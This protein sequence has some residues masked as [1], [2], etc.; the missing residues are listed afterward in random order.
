MIT[1]IKRFLLVSSSSLLLLFSAAVPVTVSA[2]GGGECGTNIG[3]NIADGAGATTGSGQP[4]DCDKEASDEG[5]GKI[6]KNIVNIFSYVV[7]AISVIM[8]IYGGFRYITSGGSSEGVGAAKSTLIYAI[9]GLVIVALAQLIV[10]FVLS[11]SSDL[12]S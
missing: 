5:I 2:L 4:L 11:Q 7:G 3:G 12:T 6:A 1:N 8:I 10:Q 9:I